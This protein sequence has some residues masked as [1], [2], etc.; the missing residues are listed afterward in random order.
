MGLLYN[1]ARMSTATT[2]TGTITLGSAVSGFLSFAGAGVANGDVVSYGI[3]DGANSEVGTGT[4]TSAG[5]TLT[6]TVTKSTNSNTAISLSGTAQVFVTARAED[7]TLATEGQAE[8]GTNATAL[9][10]P[11]TTTQ[12]IVAITQNF[13]NAV[14]RNGGMEVWQHLN[15]GTTVTVA[16]STVAYTVDGWYLA[17]AAN[18]ASTVTQV[19]GITNGSIYAARVQ[20][21]SGQ[22]GT[23]AMVFACPL[24]TDEI[25]KIRGNTVIISF[26]VS[27]GANWSP[28]L[29]ALTC[30]L[31]CGTGAVAK[32]NASAYTAETNP[33]NFPIN[34]G[35]SASSSHQVSSTGAVGS[36]ITQ[37]ELQFTWTPIGTAGAND[38]FSLDDVQLEV[39]PTGIT[40]VTPLFERTDYVLD[41]LRCARHLRRGPGFVTGVRWYGLTIESTTVGTMN[42]PLSPPMRVAPTISFLGTAGNISLNDL[43]VQSAF[44][45]LATNFS[46]PD[47]LAQQLTG[48]GTYTAGRAG[49]LVVSSTADGFLI[50]AEI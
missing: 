35:T 11:Q 8:A 39:V 19:A 37:A 23:G 1:L 17:T 20:R 31:Y 36:T 9:M 6:R 30:K 21:N 34:Y 4:Y 33:I 44:S 28:S 7:L 48:A 47:S 18:Q 46:T 10:T 43:S 5:T 27:T 2:G 3:A 45:S 40:A 32:R 15:G 13:K 22:T 41:F 26:T 29:G 16:A 24:D 49:F 50:S 14:G 25:T 38:W 12:A 42:A